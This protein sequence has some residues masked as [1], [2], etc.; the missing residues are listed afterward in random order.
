MNER[1]QRFILFHAH[2]EIHSQEKMILYDGSSLK[3]G[4]KTLIYI[5]LNRKRI[6]QQNSNRFLIQKIFEVVQTFFGDQAP[7]NEDVLNGYLR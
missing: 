1:F 3:M 6:V 2:Q 7:T 4:Y 5:I